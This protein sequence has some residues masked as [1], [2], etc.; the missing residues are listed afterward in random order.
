MTILSQFL[1]KLKAKPK[2]LEE[3]LAELDQ[4][5]VEALVAIAVENESDVLRRAAIARLDYGPVLIELSYDK[6]I[7][8]VQQN[9]R[10]RLAELADQG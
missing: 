8:G 9:A 5:S 3:R 4:L 6:A 7:T 2:T 1:S 10:Q